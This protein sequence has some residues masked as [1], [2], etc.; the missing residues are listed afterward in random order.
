MKV[1]GSNIFSSINQLQVLSELNLKEG[2]KIIGRIISR[3]MDEAILDIA[4]RQ[5]QAKIEGNP[6][7]TGAPQTFLVQTDE[8]GR[9]ILKVFNNPQ[10]YPAETAAKSNNNPVLVKTPINEG[11][12]LQKSITASLIK[13]GLKPTPENIQKVNQFIQEFQT[14]YQHTLQ[15][16][17]FTFIMAQ[18]WPVTPGTVLASWVYQDQEVRDLLWNKLPESMTEKEANAIFQKLLTGMNT[19]ASQIE[20]KLKSLTG[21]KLQNL[22]EKLNDFIQQART[23]PQTDSQTAKVFTRPNTTGQAQAELPT[24]LNLLKELIKQPLSQSSN[25]TKVNND[26]KTQL[27]L[28][29]DNPK[30]QPE[31]NPNINREHPVVTNKNINISTNTKPPISSESAPKDISAKIEKSPAGDI[32]IEANHEKV[33][34]LLDQNLALNKAILK[35]TALNGS[36]NLIPLLVNDSQTLIRECLV[37]WKEEKSNSHDKTTNQVVYMTIPTENLGDIN[38]ALKIGATG[39]RLDFRVKSEEIRKYFQSHSAEL[40]EI[41]AKENMIISVNLKETDD[42]NR[43]TF[44][45]DLWM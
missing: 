40:K 23:S 24:G 45:V 26:S 5:V 12:I 34:S 1:S 11:E 28:K 39:S 22:L 7:P 2:Q 14:K 31:S 27:N 36:S 15:P 42:S 25:Q 19:S 37:Q 3:S 16:K 38:L 41:L 21:F 20:D 33:K 32:N 13:D 9:T 17:V 44:G 18:K 10:E 35:E 29:N 43:V 30:I 4:G 6:P 8:Q